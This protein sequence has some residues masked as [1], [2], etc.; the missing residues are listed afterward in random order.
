MSQESN[1]ELPR[2]DGREFE[3][4]YTSASTRMSKGDLAEIEAQI[5]DETKSLEERLYAYCTCFT[6]QRINKNIRQ[7]LS[8]F[9]THKDLFSDTFSLSHTYAIAVKLSGRKRD[10]DTSINYARKSLELATNHAGAAHNLSES[11]LLM[12]RLQP[13]DSTDRQQLLSEAVDVVDEAINIEPHYAKFYATKARIE[14]LRGLFPEAKIAITRAI[15][16]EDSTRLDYG[17]RISDYLS[18]K[19]EIELIEATA[20]VQEDAKAKLDAAIADVRR[21]NI[22]VLSFFVA[23]ISFIIAAINISV[24]FKPNEV[25]GL[26]FV[27]AAAMLLSV[28]TFSFVFS[29]KRQLANLAFASFMALILIVLGYFGTMYWPQP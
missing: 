24:S 11:L 18:A 1:I 25:V 23:T 6:F 7:C 22:E 5:L 4:L 21:S 3:V 26:L 20:Q 19:S 15:E 17:L 29:R 14:A 13:A 28:T 2:E 8:L 12:A 10:I 27:L 16:Q 9:H